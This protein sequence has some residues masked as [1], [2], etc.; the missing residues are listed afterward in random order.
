[1]LE[2]ICQLAREAGEAIMQVYDGAK[3][4]DVVSK[5]DDSP[6]TAADLAAHR[7]IV[8]GLERLTPDLPVLSEESADIPW[9]TRQHWSSYWLVDPLDGTREFVKRNGEF[10]VNIA[11]IEDGVP[12]PGRL[13]SGAHPQI[14]VQRFVGDTDLEDTRDLAA[15]RTVGA[16]LA[17]L[18]RAEVPNALRG[19]LSSREPDPRE[20]G[21]AHARGLEQRR[22]RQAGRRRAGQRGRAGQHAEQRMQAEPQRHRHA[23]QVLHDRKRRRQQ[24]EHQHLASAEFQQR[25]TGVDADGGEEGDHQRRLQAGVQGEQGDLAAARHQHGQ[26]HHQAADHRRR[27]VVAVEQRDHAAQR[28][29]EEEGQAGEGQRLHRIEFQHAAPAPM[30]ERRA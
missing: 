23:Q 12:L 29:T 25:H 15:T 18:H 7:I 28:I 11:L 4:M 8:E 3:P 22:E 5:A 19:C 24:Q 21:A 27:Q 16:A 9:A 10:T 14:A 1:M 26:R 30:E 17:T 2:K 20:Q 6:V 13:D